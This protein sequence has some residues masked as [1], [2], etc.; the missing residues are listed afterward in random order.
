MYL[1]DIFFQICLLIAARHGG[2]F[3]RRVHV[4]CRDSCCGHRWCN[5]HC[6]YNR[7]A[8]SFGY[9]GA[10]ASLRWC[11]QPVRLRP[12]LVTSFAIEFHRKG[13][14]LVLALPWK[15]YLGFGETEWLYF[16]ILGLILAVGLD[17]RRR[18][19]VFQTKRHASE[20]LHGRVMQ[21]LTR[22]SA[23]VPVHV[24]VEYLTTLTPN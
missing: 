1:A 10:P 16:A 13:H 17:I 15:T 9:A 2:R 19:R 6:Q 12:I 5:R 14:V 7:R 4:E 22:F 3:W 21:D 23:G 8:V 24:L 11:S 20:E 18:V